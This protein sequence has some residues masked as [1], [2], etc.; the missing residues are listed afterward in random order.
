MIE[1]CMGV[2]VVGSNIELR[3]GNLLI[4]FDPFAKKA[5]N[6]TCYEQLEKLGRNKVREEKF[7]KKARKFIQD[8]QDKKTSFGNK[9]FG[10]A[11]KS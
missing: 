2:K 4:D 11:E 8:E 10:K 1:E 9:F 3:D 7:I 5:A 6:S